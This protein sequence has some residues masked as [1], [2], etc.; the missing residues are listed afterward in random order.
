MYFVYLLILNPWGRGKRRCDRKPN[1]VK[2]QKDNLIKHFIKAQEAFWLAE[3]DVSFIS[4]C[5]S[6]QA[7]SML[8]YVHCFH[9]RR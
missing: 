2:A 6:L 5:Y 9:D 7:N 8:N 4:R 3:T 1:L